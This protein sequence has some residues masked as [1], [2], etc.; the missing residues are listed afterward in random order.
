MT[1]HTKAILC[2]HIY[3]FACD[4]DPLVQLA[5]ERGLIL[6]EDA[7]EM[8]GQTYKGRP[9]GSFGQLSTM[10]FYPNKHVTT[11]EGGMVLMD[12]PQLLERCQNMRNLC[13]DPKKRRFVHE[14]LDCMR[15]YH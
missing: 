11:G 1:P 12:D 15:A 13:F 5:K 14:D 2:V 9:C 6:I 10:S 8:I 4:M 3:H 7:A